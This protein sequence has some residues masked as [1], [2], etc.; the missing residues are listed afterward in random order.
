MTPTLIRRAA[1]LALALSLPLLAGPAGAEVPEGWSDP[2]E[3]GFLQLMIPVLAVPVGIALLVAAAVYLPPLARGE[4]LTPGTRP[5]DEWF[6]GPRGGTAELE[7]RE[8]RATGGGSG[9]W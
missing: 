3:V 4:R 9:S 2:D 6:G 8:T 7:S 1:V 5:A